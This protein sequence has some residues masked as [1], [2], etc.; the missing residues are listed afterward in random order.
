MSEKKFVGYRKVNTSQDFGLQR[1]FKR[2]WSE[3]E[4][5]TEE[6]SSLKKEVES[7]K[8]QSAVKKTTV[9]KPVEKKSWD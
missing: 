9:K 6:N 1:E 3:I 2:I 4:R 5:L 8:T 7:L